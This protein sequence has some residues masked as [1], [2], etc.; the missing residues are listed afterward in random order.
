MDNNN[1]Q[2]NLAFITVNYWFLVNTISLLET[3]KILKCL[4][5]VDQAI[6]HLEIWC[7]N[8]YNSKCIEK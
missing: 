1:L 5:I 8:K 3:S 6:N 7:T 2:Y 4:K